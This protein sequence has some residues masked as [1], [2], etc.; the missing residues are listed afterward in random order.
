MKH[1]F[2]IPEKPKPCV[3]P[4]DFKVFMEHFGP[5]A[6]EKEVDAASVKM[7]VSITGSLPMV[8]K[9]MF[10]KPAGTTHPG[11]AVP[12]GKVTRVSSI[13]KAN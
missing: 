4:K 11:L 8:G 3:I 7:H 12:F 6:E 9:P 5:D 13:R 10:T 1:V 2:K